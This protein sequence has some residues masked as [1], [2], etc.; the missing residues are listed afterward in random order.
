VKPVEESGCGKAR[1]SDLKVCG[2][3]NSDVGEAT[4]ESDDR[5]VGGAGRWPAAAK[6]FEAMEVAGSRAE[7]LEVNV[8]GLGGDKVSSAGAGEAEVALNLAIANGSLGVRGEVHVAAEA[9]VAAKKEAA[10]FA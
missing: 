2:A 10:Y 1:G 5:G 9:S 7:A 6:V 3:R 8:E 4:G